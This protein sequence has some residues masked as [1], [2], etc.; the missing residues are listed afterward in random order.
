MTS[1][2]VI[3]WISPGKSSFLDGETEAPSVGGIMA[4]GITVQALS[5]H[6]SPAYL[7]NASGS[8]I[9][10]PSGVC[11]DAARDDRVHGV[12]CVSIWDVEHGWLD[13]VHELYRWQVERTGVTRVPRVCCG[14]RVRRGLQQV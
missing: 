8:L 9:S 5:L 6:N 14:D 13:S 12:H 3:R 10:K 4:L 2:V 11:H 7:L 1:H